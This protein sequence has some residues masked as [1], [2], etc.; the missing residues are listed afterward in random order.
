MKQLLQLGHHL[1]R[2]CISLQSSAISALS[3]SLVE[4][5]S[6]ASDNKFLFSRLT[7]L[8]LHHIYINKWQ[9]WNMASIQTL[10]LQRCPNV[11]ITLTNFVVQR[12]NFS[13]L[14]KPRIFLCS[15]SKFISTVFRYFQKVAEI[16][17]LQLLMQGNNYYP[18]D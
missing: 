17:E 5:L 7:D 1:Q 11:D 2:L 3:S 13:R 10:S 9:S 14:K 16:E 12:P 6:H 4:A 18:L 15:E 8:E